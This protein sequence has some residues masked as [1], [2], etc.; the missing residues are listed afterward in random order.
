MIVEGF[1]DASE[2]LGSTPSVS[3]HPVRDI[4]C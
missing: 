2:H 3:T 4:G 1:I